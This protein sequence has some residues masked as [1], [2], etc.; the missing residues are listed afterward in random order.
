MKRT[1]KEFFEQYH[2]ERWN[3]EGTYDERRKAELKMFEDWYKEMEVGDHCH[4]K[5]WSDV[6][7]CTV[8]KRTKST[9]TVRYDKAERD[10]NWKPEWIVGGFSA[11][12]TNN[13]DQEWIISEDPDGR[14]ETF[15]WRKTRNCFM[16]TAEEKLFP[17]WMKFYD[18]NF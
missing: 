6:S 14:V 12:C 17:E 7:P 5:H 10:P 4:I 15:R 13:E 8:I 11:H 3:L 9:I 2:T 16:N 1:A 18:Y